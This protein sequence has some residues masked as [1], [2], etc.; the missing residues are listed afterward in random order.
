M[1]EKLFRDNQG[2]REE[3]L[4]VLNLPI[5]QE[6]FGL[7]SAMTS[8]RGGVEMKPGVP[9]DT[10]CAH[11]LELLRGSQR[12]ID[13]MWDLTREMPLEPEAESEQEYDYVIPESHHRARQ[14]HSA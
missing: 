9:F 2:K 14:Q 1:S 12:V 3:W 5:T 7:L 10:L 6:V 4:K 11:K 13:K 8:P